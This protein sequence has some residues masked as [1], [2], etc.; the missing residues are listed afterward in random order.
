MNF[1]LI[2]LALTSFTFSAPVTD[3]LRLISFQEGQE[4]WMTETELYKVLAENS[5]KHFHFV[6]KTSGI[7]DTLQNDNDE[8]DSLI[9]PYPFKVYYPSLV[10]SIKGK[11]SSKYVESF[12]TNFSSFYN[13]GYQSSYGLQSAQYLYDEIITLKNSIKRDDVVLTVTKFNHA[14]SSPDWL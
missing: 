9:S 3:E 14:L 8:G 7:W 6:D 10:Q 5:G 13:R 1:N 4:Q 12:L 11:V 2:F